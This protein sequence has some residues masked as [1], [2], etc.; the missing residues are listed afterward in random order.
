MRI[1]PVRPSL[2]G[3]Y[4]R[5]SHDSGV[6]RFLLDLREGAAGEELIEEL[7]EPRLQRSV[8]GR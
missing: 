4:E 7:M 8:S 1:K 3:S 2:P 5:M 6:E